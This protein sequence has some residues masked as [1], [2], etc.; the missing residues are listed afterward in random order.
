MLERLSFITM[1]GIV[2]DKGRA[3]VAAIVMAG[4]ELLLTEIF[5]A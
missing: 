5:Y 3:A 4:N 2:M 1:D